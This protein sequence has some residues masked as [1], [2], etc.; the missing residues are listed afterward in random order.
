[1]SSDKDRPGRTGH[2]K[3]FI[4][5]TLIQGIVIGYAIN[6]V[7]NKTAIVG[8][9]V[10]LLT[11]ISLEQKKPE[12]WPNIGEKYRETVKQIREKYEESTKS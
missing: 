11:G 4:D 10:G 6:M 12:D 2:K 5:T 1:M 7:L 3:S 8:A 9:V